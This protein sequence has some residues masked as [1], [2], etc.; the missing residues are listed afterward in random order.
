MSPQE[1]Q[2]DHLL[3][4]IAKLSSLLEHALR[5]S[6][7]TN[8]PLPNPYYSCLFSE[9]P[10]YAFSTSLLKALLNETPSLSSGLGRVLSF[11]NQ[12]RGRIALAL[13]TVSLQCLAQYL[14]N[15]GVE[16]GV[17]LALCLLM[18]EPECLTESGPDTVE[19]IAPEPYNMLYV[20][21]NSLTQGAYTVFVNETVQA[22]IRRMAGKV[23]IDM[24]YGSEH[25]CPLLADLSHK[26]DCLRMTIPALSDSDIVLS[27]FANAF[28]RALYHYGTNYGPDWELNGSNSKLLNRVRSQ[29]NAAEQFCSFVRAK[30]KQASIV[31]GEKGPKATRSAL[32]KCFLLELK[33]H[34]KRLLPGTVLL[35]FSHS[36]LDF[37]Y[38]GKDAI[39]DNFDYMTLRITDQTQT[40]CIFTNRRG[41]QK[42]LLSFHF[43]AGDPLTVNDQRQSLQ[44]INLRITT[45]NDL[46][47]IKK[48]LEAIDIRCET[49]YTRTGP[50]T[51]RSSSL[52]IPL[53]TASEI[54]RKSSNSPGLPSQAEIGVR[55]RNESSNLVEQLDYVSQTATGNASQSS[56][57]ELTR[58]P[59]CHATSS[60]KARESSHPFSLEDPVETHA[61]KEIVDVPSTAAETSQNGEAAGLCPNSI[62]NTRT[63]SYQEVNQTFQDCPARNTRSNSSQNGKSVATVTKLKPIPPNTQ[64]SLIFPRRRPREKLYTAPTKTMVD[65]DEDLRASHS[66]VRQKGLED[67]ELTCM[68]SPVSNGAECVFK[69]GPKKYNGGH[70]RTNPVTKAKGRAT[71]RKIGGKRRIKKTVKVLSAAKKNYENDLD[72]RKQNFEA[73]STSNGSSP[74]EKPIVT[75]NTCDTFKGAAST[76]HEISDFCLLQKQDDP[77]GQAGM[78]PVSEGT[79]STVNKYPRHEIEADVPIEEN[80]TLNYSTDD[81]HYDEKNRGRGQSVARKLIAALHASDAPDDHSDDYRHVSFEEA[82]HG[83]GDIPEFCEVYNGHP[84]EQLRVDQETHGNNGTCGLSESSAPKSN[85]QDITILKA[86][87]TSSHA[88]SQGSSFGDNACDSQSSNLGK[89]VAMFLT[90]GS[91]ERKRARKTSSLVKSSS[92]EPRSTESIFGSNHVSPLTHP[93]GHECSFH[94]QSGE[95]ESSKITRFSGSS[96]AA[97]DEIVPRNEDENGCRTT[98]GTQGERIISNTDY[99]PS[100]LESS[101][102]TIVDKNGSPRLLKNEHVATKRRPSSPLVE[103]TS[104]GRL[105]KISD[106]DDGRNFQKGD[107]RDDAQAEDDYTTTGCMKIDHKSNADGPHRIEEIVEESEG[108]GHASN[109]NVTGIERVLPFMNRLRGHTQGGPF[110]LLEPTST[111]YSTTTQGQNPAH[112]RADYGLTLNG[113]SAS[114]LSSNGVDPGP[115]VACELSKSSSTTGPNEWQTS[116]QELHQQMQSTLLSNNEQ[117]SRQIDSERT[118]VNKVLVA[119]R[120]QCHGVLDQLFKAQMER[121]RLCNQQIDSIKQQHADVCQELICR[122]EEN[123]R[124]LG[125]VEGNQ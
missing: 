90:E 37:I 50:D 30:P 125:A 75:I 84:D 13:E 31:H 54:D 97:S 8:G 44:T 55:W 36:R 47:K 11:T 118:T 110:K 7:A 2:E 60:P 74:I 52:V 5:E 39:E 101:A 119:Y 58:T 81:Q 108:A 59:T 27:F 61:P 78:N 122:L 88:E 1:G 16:A 91:Q 48:S 87:P 71:T 32:P 92:I 107:G 120:E 113:T 65:W 124:G 25:R 116:L 100:H 6:K 103:Q 41:G 79:W 93:G 117:L 20:V 51:R 40:R 64:E 28:I 68:S 43:Q 45:K 22:R 105:R 83:V 19:S 67:D 104:S 94:E 85:Q 99:S 111:E 56:L 46:G 42:P 123:E 49:G 15:S 29:E 102:W 10:L 96:G 95:V 98:V 12:H 63:T 70:A 24:V 53:D 62:E 17:E 77:N 121:I 76:S 114:K 66:P 14:L 21:Q 115:K 112:E 106:Q 35:L 80:K 89:R 18:N 33:R 109:M 73:S 82:R 69:Q 26:N 23:L 4:C 38:C 3:G 72:M 86:Y 57:T 34:A 9:T